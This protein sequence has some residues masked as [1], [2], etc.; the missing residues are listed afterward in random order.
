[1]YATALPN[2]V[3]LPHT[4]RPMPYA[5]AEPLVCMARVPAG[6]PFGA[7]DGRLTYI[8]FL[9]CSHEERQHL[10][11]LAR[12]A[13]MLSTELPARLREVDDAGE[14]LAMIL[15]SEQ[16]VIARR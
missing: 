6:I 8:F 7:P 5:T 11:V 1:M 14:A 15:E 10:C 13:M 9:V 12:L 2:G 16:Q 4:R 3:A